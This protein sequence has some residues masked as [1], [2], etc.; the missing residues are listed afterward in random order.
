MR[1]HER[2]ICF[3]NE[4]DFVLLLFLVAGSCSLVSR[5]GLNGSGVGE[6]FREKRDERSAVST[7]NNLSKLGGMFHHFVQMACPRV[8]AQSE[9]AWTLKVSLDQ[10]HFFG[11]HVVMPHLVHAVKELQEDGCEAAALAAG[12]QVAAL[13]E[14]VA[15]GEP[16]F[17]QQHL[18]TLQ[19]PVERITEQLHQGH[20][21]QTRKQQ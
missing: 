9:S 19:S 10:F 17:L 2:I 13:A 12:A 4:L 20:H 6:V 16:L 15:E 1:E 14:L 8:H 18:E 21:L 7:L 5:A 11:A 3:L